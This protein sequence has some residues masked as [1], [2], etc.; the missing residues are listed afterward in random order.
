[1]EI[2][3]SLIL[4]VLFIF[5]YM[6]IAEIFVVLFRITGL[7]E[8]KSRFQVI[9]M[10]TN[11]GYTTK[12]AELIS[13]NKKRRKLARFV[14]MFGY[15]FTVT[16]VST[17]VNIF[18]QFRKTYA[19]GAVASIP[20][21]IIV[22]LLIRVFKKSKL[23]KAFVDQIIRKISKRIAYEENKNTIIIIDEYDGLI[24]ARI[25]LY[26]LPRQLQEK[27]LIESNIK[28]DYGLNIILKINKDRK[29]VPTANTTFQEGDT[30]VAMGKEENIKIVFGL[31][32]IN[33]NNIMKKTK[34]V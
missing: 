26:I 33:V 21:I 28:N 31:S 30:I 3:G 11:S 22:F 18:F 8:E 20:I 25:D 6:I 14:M 7:T 23:I 2:I 1:M 5:V 4:F 12:E 17:V 16:I 27:T 19:G 34:V 29:E 15:A 9:S 10:L 13:T 24:M 32:N